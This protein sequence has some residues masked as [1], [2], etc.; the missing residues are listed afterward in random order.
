MDRHYGRASASSPNHYVE[1]LSE[2]S[3]LLGLGLIEATR[4]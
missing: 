4:R 3:N 1:V 2:H